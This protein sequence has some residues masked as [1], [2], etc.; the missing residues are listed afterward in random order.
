MLRWFISLLARECWFARFL[1]DNGFMAK[2]N[3]DPIGMVLVWL[4][5][6]LVVMAAGVD[7]VAFIVSNN[8]WKLVG[9]TAPI[10]AMGI[11][12]FVVLGKLSENEKKRKDSSK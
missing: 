2:K 8:Y 1:W 5:I 11:L 12:C 9:L 7:L 3:N 10:W 6:A 4:G